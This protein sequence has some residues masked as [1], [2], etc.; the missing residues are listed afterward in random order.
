LRVLETIP[1]AC[2]PLLFL[3]LLE[4]LWQTVAPKSGKVLS[5][6]PKESIALQS[7]P[8][9]EP[10]KIDKSGKLGSSIKVLNRRLPKSSWG[11]ADSSI[12][13]SASHYSG[14]EEIIRRWVP[15]LKS[16]AKLSDIQIDTSG[17]LIEAKSSQAPV[18]IVDEMRLLLEVEI[19]V[20]AEKA[21]VEK[22]SSKIQGEI[23]KSYGKLA[24]ESFVSKAPPEVITL[25]KNRL[26]E[27]ESK[28]SK[29]LEQ[30][31]NYP[32]CK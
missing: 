18:V 20:V 4:E 13:K 19:D 29:L 6:C 3:V 1:K 10:K 2:S 26:A 11:D 30:K 25:E 7:Y 12:A 17:Q 22:E 5:E 27:F 24:N 28:L 21:R 15:Y 23:K 9:P 16:L 8:I 14:S 32:Y 31:I